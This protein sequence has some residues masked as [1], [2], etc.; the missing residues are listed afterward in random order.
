[1]PSGC[2][3]FVCGL[4]GLAEQL[5][6]LKQQRCP[7]C[8]RTETLNRHSRLYGNDPLTVDGRCLRGQRVWCCHRGRRRGCGRSFSVFLTDVLPRHTFPAVLL[9][10]W[11]VELL[12]GLSLKAAVDKLKLPFALETVYQLRRKLRDG[13]ARL[14]PWLCREEAPP[15]HTHLD[16][17][18]QTLGHLQSVFPR[19]PCPPAD[20]QL[21]FQRPFLG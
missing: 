1:M 7:H 16:P 2:W 20:F 19:S 11:L 21:H 5:L 18:F 13:L 17:L 6:R 15:A 10:S 12:A 3:R 4:Q 9:W 8:G 14:R